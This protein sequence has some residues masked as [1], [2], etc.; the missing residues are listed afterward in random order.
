MSDDADRTVDGE[1]PA[2]QPRA[3]AFFQLDLGDNGGLLAP[4]SHAELNEWIHTEVN[5]W[6]W[7]VQ[8]SYGN[9][10]QGFRDA[11]SSLSE[12]QGRGADAERH[13]TSNAEH[14]RQQLQTCRN[15]IEAAFLTKRLP[16]SSTPLGR[17]IDAYRRQHGDRAGS[18]YLG[19]FAPPAQGHNFQPNELDAWRALVDGLVDRFD[20]GVNLGQARVSSS[21]EAFEQLRQKA[22]DLADSRSLEY[23]AL[24]R[25]YDLLVDA[26]RATAT[27]QIGEFAAAQAT[28]D[29]Q[30]TKQFAEHQS[31]MEALRKTFR[32]EI[33][34]RAPAE[35]WES[36]RTEHRGR[37]KLY[38]VLVF[39][40]M[41]VAALLLGWQIHDL[42]SETPKGSSPDAWR[43]ALLALLGLFA[44]W[45]LRLVVRMFLS[46]VHFGDGRQRAPGHGQDLL[47]IARGGSSGQQGRPPVDPAGPVPPGVRRH[48]QRR[49]HTS[50][51]VRVPDSSGEERMSLEPSPARLAFSCV[52]I[53]CDLTSAQ[54]PRAATRHDRRQPG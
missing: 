42:L 32:E 24:R 36:K 44:V 10:E 53:A 17:R 45:G 5:F 16:H 28:R 4:T 19:V 46:H 23:D 27:Q 35:Y 8:R 21:E 43:L 37:S 33:A 6:N 22:Q 29:E 31:G 20:L 15:H 9:H 1:Q 12:A 2:P 34:L 7:C 40:G 41:V 18:F 38:A 11:Y 30:F 14:A 13:L 54:L 50:V 3:E 47:G 52:L 48:R 26:A 51:D 25:E 49:R 39:G